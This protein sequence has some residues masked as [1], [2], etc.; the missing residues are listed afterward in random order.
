MSRHAFVVAVLFGSIVS[1][2][3]GAQAQ[4]RLPFMVESKL[5]F[6][7]GDA[8]VPAIT[9]VAAE[10]PGPVGPAVAP[11]AVLERG[12]TSRLLPLYASTA[13]LQALDVHSTLQVI[14]RGGGEGNPLLQGVVSNR[15]A[16]VAAKA[17]VA[18]STIY[19]ASRIARHSKI[20]AFVTLVGLNSAYAFVVSHNYKLA[21]QM[22]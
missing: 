11:A 21:H 22:R 18:A 17:A 9:P 7:P 15:G 2:A 16:F 10:T 12:R 20:G 1:F 6:M 5:L 19:A 3:T 14:S 8:T 4:D 13:L